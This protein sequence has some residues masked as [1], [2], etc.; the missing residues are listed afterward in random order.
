MPVLKLASKQIKILVPF[1]FLIHQTLRKMTKTC[2]N[3]I[4]FYENLKHLIVFRDYDSV[5]ICITNPEKLGFFKSQ[6]NVNLTMFTHSINN[7][8][9]N[10]YIIHN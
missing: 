7:K 2:L 4:E 1:T 8:N 5:Q 9:A 6:F 10:T 3:E